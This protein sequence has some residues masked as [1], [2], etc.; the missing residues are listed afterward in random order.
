MGKRKAS[1]ASVA[2][3]AKTTDNGSGGGGAGSAAG[4]VSAEGITGLVDTVKQDLEA[5]KTAALA[6]A[7]EE[8]T[9]TTDE[10]NARLK[11]FAAKV[12]AIKILAR[13]L[14]V[15]VVDSTERVKQAKQ[16]MEATHLQLQNVL[17]E[18]LHVLNEIKT[19]QS[20]RSRAEDLELVTRD[21]YLASDAASGEDKDEHHEMLGR[22]QFEAE[23]R[24][25]LRSDLEER[26]YRKTAI[27]NINEKKRAMI[28]AA[29]DA[30]TH[31]LDACNKCS[32]VFGPAS[33]PH[34]EL[35]AKFRASH[36]LADRLP[37]PLHALLMTVA[38]YNIAYEARSWSVHIAGD[39]AAVDKFEAE[40]DACETY[41]YALAR[42]EQGDNDD[43]EDERDEDDEDEEEGGKR[44]K[45]AHK[46][47]TGQSK[48]ATAPAN[49]HQL[50]FTPHP[51]SLELKSTPD[52]A[53]SLR[54]VFRHYPLL[55]IV[56]TT[57]QSPK[58][59]L[60]VLQHVAP[61]DSGKTPSSP[62]SPASPPPPVMF[63]LDRLGVED[64]RPRLTG[65]IVPAVQDIAGLTDA[66][67]KTRPWHWWH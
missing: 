51:L 20:Y 15:R 36:P 62:S 46:S 6:N 1:D 9:A 45:D 63:M 22:L 38:G 53:K 14:A 50:L 3:K 61:A 18:H 16:G 8:D 5:I 67:R 59:Q 26:Q 4:R 39:A 10:L 21:E 7:D 47:Q 2:K 27:S 52:A 40:V 30:V 24:A 31:L 35:L 37:A 28:K 29:P 55:H 44:S 12:T 65:T 66:G 23:E 48:T 64:Y 32:D 57:E 58:T 60:P 42:K 54:L 43:V 25:R 49:L 34:D 19:C 13:Q 56:T 17:Y 11:T 33:M 41:M